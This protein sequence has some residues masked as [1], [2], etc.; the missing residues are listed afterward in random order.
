[1]QTFENPSTVYIFT[2]VY[3]NKRKKC[4]SLFYFD[5]RSTFLSLFNFIF[6]Y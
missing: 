4:S 1:M 6:I 3:Y 2:K 5:F